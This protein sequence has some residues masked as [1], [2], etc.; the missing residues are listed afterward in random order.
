MNEFNQDPALFKT[1]DFLASPI[2]QDESFDC[3]GFTIGEKEYAIQFEKLREKPNFALARTA[4]ENYIAFKKCE[5]FFRQ[6]QSDEFLI[7]QAKNAGD[8]GELSYLQNKG[9]VVCVYVCSSKT[10]DFPDIF[11]CNEKEFMS[12][13]YSALME[14]CR[15]NFAGDKISYNNMKSPIVERWLL[16]IDDNENEIPIRQKVVKKLVVVPNK[17]GVGHARRVRKT[18]RSTTDVWYD[19]GNGMMELVHQSGGLV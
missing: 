18:L 10:V 16:G 15:R 17:K 6:S 11:Y 4:L 5:M 14:I 19:L 13:I 2:V 12:Q 8:A 3:V 9:S 1:D 7:L